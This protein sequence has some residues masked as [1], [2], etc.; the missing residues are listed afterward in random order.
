MS[1]RLIILFLLFLLALGI[2]VKL[3][4]DPSFWHTASLSFSKPVSE[5]SGKNADLLFFPAHITVS[6]GQDQK[7]AVV[8]RPLNTLASLIE[9]DIAFDP[10]VLENIQVLPG[11]YFTHPAIPISQIDYSSGRIT[12]VLE[13]NIMTHEKGIVAYISF[14]TLPVY[15]TV[16]TKISFLPKTL[17]RSQTGNNILSKTYCANITIVPFYVPAQSP[18]EA[19]PNFTSSASGIINKR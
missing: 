18:E 4:Y 17:I 11:N 2:Y 16:Q 8:I 3:V 13:G 12:Y 7:V 19:A 14:A 15:Q 1:I 5:E 9:L 6:A 10:A